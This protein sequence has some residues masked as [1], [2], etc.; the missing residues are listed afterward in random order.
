MNFTCDNGYLLEGANDLICLNN[1]KYTAAVP[2]C[3]GEAETIFLEIVI[4]A[5][6]YCRGMSYLLDWTQ[7]P[8]LTKL[9]RDHSRPNNN[10][11]L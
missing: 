7:C 4:H 10:L 6:M 9:C 8:V 2:Q 5:H 3:V 11:Q 1:A